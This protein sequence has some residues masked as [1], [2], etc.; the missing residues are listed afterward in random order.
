M[1]LDTPSGD[2]VS[3]LA[4]A[5]RNI[6]EMV[7]SKNIADAIC[8][9]YPIEQGHR[10]GIHVR[11]DQGVCY[12]Y[13]LNLSFDYGFTLKLSQLVNDPDFKEAVKAAGEILERYNVRRS[14]LGDI[15]NDIGIL[16]RDFTGALCH[17]D[18]C[19]IKFGR[20][21]KSTVRKK[22]PSKLNVPAQPVYKPLVFS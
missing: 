22:K 16:K 15:A 10:W 2:I 9:K 21:V 4:D 8:K 7:L 12:I 17:D 20:R 11:A 6:N 18:H 13:N 3:N 1:N 14:R 19:A 5:N